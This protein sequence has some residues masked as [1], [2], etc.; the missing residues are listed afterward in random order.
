MSRSKITYPKGSLVTV[1]IYVDKQYKT[2][3]WTLGEESAQGDGVVVPYKETA[4]NGVILGE[5][6]KNIKTKIV[7]QNLGPQTSSIIL[8]KIVKISE[9]YGCELESL[10]KLILPHQYYSYSTKTASN[11]SIQ[12]VGDKI[13]NRK[14]SKNTETSILNVVQPIEEKIEGTVIE[15]IK[16]NY[17]NGQILIILPSVE[18]IEK[19]EQQLPYSLKKETVRLDK[20]SN[21]DTILK[22]VKNEKKIALGTRNNVLQYCENL[23]TIIVVETEHVG[24]K[25]M[26]KPYLESKILAKE[27]LES[28]NNKLIYICSNPGVGVLTKNVKTIEKPYKGYNVKL[29]DLTELP[30]MERENPKTILTEI[31]KKIASLADVG[32]LNIGHY[33]AIGYKVS[34]LG[35]NL[36]CE[37]IQEN[38]K[39]DII[40]LENIDRILETPTLQPGYE[41]RKH[42]IKALN[43]MKNNGMLI[44][45]TKYKTHPI[46]QSYET[47]T[48]LQGL[49]WQHSQAKKYSLPPYGKIIKIETKNKTQLKNLKNRFHGGLL[50]KD[51][52]IYL[53]VVP[54][55]EYLNYLNNIK[56]TRNTTIKIV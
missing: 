37:K 17:K 33:N 14:I 8:E 24:H 11:D 5:S 48:H 43:S 2:L 30:Y 42:L 44:V 15:Y 3:V 39:Y 55:E 54:N 35:V 51:K 36:G 27:R 7:K 50:S 23:Q 56:Q 29:I 28:L 10:Y 45:V 18:K 16:E 49:S 22:Y 13:V 4:V 34:K 12:S 6:N 1:L 46:L 21:Y 26:S 20:K 32:G 25:L 53:A 31:K 47:K 52:Q 19:L 40:I 41:A 9:K 38:K